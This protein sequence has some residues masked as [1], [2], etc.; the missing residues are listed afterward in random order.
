MGGFELGVLTYSQMLLLQG[1][2]E[3]EFYFYKYQNKFKFKTV[4]Q[5]FV[6]IIGTHPQVS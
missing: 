2:L 3:D 4:L 6:N 1:T 5:I